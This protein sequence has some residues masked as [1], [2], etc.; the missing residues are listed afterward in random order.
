M[1][2]RSVLEHYAGSSAATNR[3]TNNDFETVAREL[4][5]SALSPGVADAFRSDQTPPISEMVGHL[6]ERSDPQQRAGVLNQILASIGP[7]L[8]S[9]V[10]GGALGN[11]L[12]HA[13]GLGTSG[14]APSLSPEQAAKVTPEQAR[15]ITD[16][17]ERADPGI[18]DRLG[19]FYAEHPQLVK[20]LGGAALAIVLGK[21]A[22]SR[23]T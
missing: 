2:L 20:G 8:L 22:N 15:E 12:R 9:G 7:G 5:P 21:L 1:D 18:A 16:H 11:L 10:A 19:Q 17:A 4:S 3:D 14:S 6:F 23:N 13:G